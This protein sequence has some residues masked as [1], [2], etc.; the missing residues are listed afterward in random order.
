V[1]WAVPARSRTPAQGV[2][3]EQFASVELNLE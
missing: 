2:C 3:P 1:A